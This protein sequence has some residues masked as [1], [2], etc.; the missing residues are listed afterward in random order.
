MQLTLDGASARALICLSIHP[1]YQLLLSFGPLPENLFSS[2]AD[3]SASMWKSLCLILVLLGTARAASL[4]PCP[5]N[6]QCEHLD[7][8]KIHA[9]CNSFDILRKLQPKQ[10]RAIVSFS[11]NNITDIDPKIKKLFSLK[12]LDVSGNRITTL[13]LP[14]L[15]GLTHLNLSSNH[16]KDFKPDALPRSLINLDISFN[17]LG[18][19]PKELTLLRNLQYLNISGNPVYCS[20][21]LVEVRNA[22]R[23][24]N[25]NV[26][27]P[28]SCASPTHFKG[29]SW[30]NDEICPNKGI[31]DQM[32]GDGTFYEGSGSGDLPLISETEIGTYADKIEDEF[33]TELHSTNTSTED[34]DYEGSGEDIESEFRNHPLKPCHINCS[35]PA[36]LPANDTNNTISV[37]DG[38]RI[39]F[40]D[41][42]GKK[43]EETSTSTTEVPHEEA[44]VVVANNKPLE[45]ELPKG[46]VE[47]S[48]VEV[49]NTTTTA[50]STAIV[51]PKKSKSTYILLAVLCIV[52]VMIIVFAIYKTRTNRRGKKRRQTDADN[53][54]I[55]KKPMQEMTELAPLT[56]LPE[57]ETNNTHLTNGTKNGKTVDETDEEKYDGVEFR[58]KQESEALLTPEAKRVTIKAGEI[59]GSIPRTPLLINRHISSD[60]NVITTPSLNQRL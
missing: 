41:I 51:A 35:T 37:L 45:S 54:G 48:D 11:V 15:P 47:K 9:S 10:A 33:L 31:W 8:D 6:C 49:N 16:I 21:A 60:G 46:G 36:P 52:I 7:G 43:I 55:N 38:A 27:D 25:V 14:S 5:D 58:K 42:S 17:S 4:I 29:V 23:E 24:A 30:Q 39:L 34:T 32:L 20:C 3:T 12:K 40:E 2:F 44:V 18:D 28:V 56:K 1:A 57:Q 22:L 26:Y 50:P 59:P 19:I 13:N 53:N